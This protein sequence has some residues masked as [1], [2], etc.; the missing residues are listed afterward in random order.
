MDEKMDISKLRENLEKKF[1]VYNSSKLQ[2]ISP[3]KFEQFLKAKIGVVDPESENY[4]LD[5]VSKQRDLSVKFHWGHNHDFGSFNLEGRMGDR[6]I[7][8][9]LRFLS[10]FPVSLS[11]LSNK[12]ILDV[13]RWTGGTTLLLA[14]L[15]NHVLAI[16]EVKKYADTVS[17]LVNSFGISDRVSVNP[18]SIYECNSVKFHEKYDVV[19]FP[20]VIYHLSDPVLALRI[21]FNAL[22]VGG[23][24]LVE[25]AGLASSEPLCR[26]EGNLI[27]HDSGDVGDLNRGGWNWF[28]PS[29]SALF[30]MMR[31]AGFDEVDT[32]WD[33]DTQRV[34]GYAK[35]NSKVSMCK[36]GFSVPSIK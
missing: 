27:Y 3:E 20:G 16:E 21:L 30:R 2:G 5:E 1:S 11:D 35:K 25:S 24:I 14:A 33:A 31:E 32:K 4:S 26:F 29:A 12:S 15:D 28:L 22:K 19:Y 7:N 36:A 23:C 8:L 34:F 9:M 13:G 10:I 6:H 17:F 18:L